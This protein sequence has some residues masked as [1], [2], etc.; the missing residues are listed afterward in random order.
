MFTGKFKFKFSISVSFIVLITLILLTGINEIALS[1]CF[2]SM[3]HEL[4]HLLAIVVLGGRVEGINLKAFAAEIVIDERTFSFKG[5]ALISVCGPLMNLLT[6]TSSI[7]FLGINNFGLCSIILGIFHL[8]P[9][10]G[11][12]GGNALNALISESK[13]ETIFRKTLVIVSIIFI[14]LI[15]FFGVYILIMTKFNF[16]CIIM[17]LILIFEA[18]RKKDSGFLK[19]KK[20]A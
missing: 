16:S 4:G 11:L 12:D 20:S 8:L 19:L 7:V 14:I 3:L 18:V 10:V 9:V 17:A 5:E 6:G 13:H 2:A 1:A 15:L